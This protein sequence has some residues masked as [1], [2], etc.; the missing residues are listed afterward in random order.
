MIYQD[1]RICVCPLPNRVAKCFKKSCDLRSTPKLPI[2]VP[3]FKW[4]LKENLQQKKI[5]KISAK[6]GGQ[7]PSAILRMDDS[8]TCSLGNV[9]GCKIDADCPGSLFCCFDF[10][11]GSKCVDPVPLDILTGGPVHKGRGYS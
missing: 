6:D 7:C 1:C 10:C 9:P 2:I 5:L 11:G 8:K 4:D 3:Y